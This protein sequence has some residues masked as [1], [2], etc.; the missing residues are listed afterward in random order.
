MWVPGSRVPNCGSPRFFRQVGV[1]GVPFARFA[2]RLG[3]RRRRDDRGSQRRRYG[4]GRSVPR[5]HGDRLPQYYLSCFEALD[6]E[7]AQS[8][9]EM[10]TEF[11]GVVTLHRSGVAQS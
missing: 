1:P 5:K 8:A 6:G 9:R 11:S 10:V 7:L 3:P 4:V 2:A